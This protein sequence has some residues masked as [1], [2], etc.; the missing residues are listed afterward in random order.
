MT[1]SR[2]YLI[3]A[4]YDWIADNNLTPH[5][6]VNADAAEVQV[7]EKYVAD[8]RIV[9]NCSAEATRKLIINNKA[10]E[11][12]ARFDGI[13]WHIYVPIKNILAIYAQENGRGMVFEGEDEDEG[14]SDT[15][16]S[17]SAS[18]SPAKPGRPNLKIV[19]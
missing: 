2:P 17:A 9:L 6:V 8:G 18:L 14:D 13:I 5:V 12:D 7:P 1:S 10:L 15:S 16:E 19:K 11:F 4:I 3:R